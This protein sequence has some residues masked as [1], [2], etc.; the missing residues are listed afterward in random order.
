MM[1]NN[2]NS[3]LSKQLSPEEAVG[4][5]AGLIVLIIAIFYILRYLIN[6]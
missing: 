6:I 4:V 2:K 5:I 1:K 3:R